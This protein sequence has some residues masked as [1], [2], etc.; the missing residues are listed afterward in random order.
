MSS[1][2]MI[3]FLI[4][5]V[6]LSGCGGGNSGGNKPPARHSILIQVFDKETNLAISEVELVILEIN[7]NTNIISNPYQNALNQGAY[8]IYLKK[9]GYL[10]RG[11][12][13]NLNRDLILNVYLNP[14]DINNEAYESI[15]G[16][17]LENGNEYAN[18]FNIYA[19][20]R[21]ITDYTEDIIDPHGLFNISSVCGDIVVS[22]YTKTGDSLAKVK[23]Q[24]TTLTDGVPLTNLSLALPDSP[25]NYN[26]N[27]P[28][29]DLFV[30]KLNDGSVLGRQS[31]SATSY[32]FGVDLIPGDSL[33]LESS[34]PVGDAYYFTRLSAGTGGT[35][36]I[37]YPANVAQFTINNSGDNL[38]L[39]FTPVSFASYYEVYAIQTKDGEGQVPFQVIS[40]SGTSVKIPKYLL[41]PDADTTLIYLRSIQLA[42]FD[43]N[44]ILAGSQ[45]YQS[46]SY[47]EKPVNFDILSLSLIQSSNINNFNKINDNIRTKYRL[48]YSA[49]E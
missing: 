11:Y 29:A 36:N 12:I 39:N 13:I 41:S 43:I 28:S 17:V 21:W 47:T 14:T 6:L 2:K 24:K 23:Y 27:K 40:L 49:L 22:A 1:K 42:G 31:S 18:L 15:S 30:A 8:T 48:N 32:S 26:G 9:T 20:N 4:L 46:Y 44:N 34:K 38:V 35:Q 33:T 45:S 25:I 10:S 19:G 37:Q 5:V 7:E 16:K 3:L